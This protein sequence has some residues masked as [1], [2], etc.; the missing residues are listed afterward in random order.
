MNLFV[1]TNYKKNYIIQ[2]PPTYKIKTVVRVPI[3]STL[4]CSKFHLTSRI[5]IAA[6]VRQTVGGVEIVRILIADK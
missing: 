1:R 5:K 3:K 4:P 6:L 2:A